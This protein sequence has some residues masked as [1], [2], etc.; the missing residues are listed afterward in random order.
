MAKYKPSNENQMVMLPISLQDQLVSG[1]L[2]HTISEL[3]DKHV[4]LS[5]FD[6]RYNNDLI[7]AAAIHPNVRAPVARSGTDVPGDATV[8]VHT[9]GC[10]H[11]VSDSEYMTGLLFEA[12]Y[13]ITD[14][15]AAADCY[16]VNS[17]TVKNP[18]EEHFVTLVRR[19]RAT[20][21][22]VIVAGCVPAG[23]PSGAEWRDVSVVSVRQIHRVT[24]V[25]SEALRGNTVRLFDTI[26]ANA[27]AGGNGAAR[28]A[29]P[30]RQASR[31]DGAAAASSSAIVDGDGAGVGSSAGADDENP[32]A[33]AG[34]S[35]REPPRSLPSL[36]LPKVRR[37]RFIEI[38][39]VNVGCLNSCTYCKTKHAR[40]DLQ[41]WPVAEILQRVR[42]C[43]AEGVTEI[44]LT[45][46]D[47]G[48]YGIDIGTDIVRLMREILAVLESTDVMVRLGMTN[49]PYLM[50]H[51]DAI[52]SLFL[53][54]NCFEFAHLP[55]QSGSDAI[56]DLM[57]RE[58]TV[59]D[60]RTC[61]AKLRAAA[62]GIS[63][64]TD[65]I[66]AFPFE[67]EAEWQQTMRLCNE[68]Q[69]PVLNI[70][71][72]YP[73][74][75]TP[76]AA[77][78]QIAS[79]VAKRRTQ[80]ISQMFNDRQSLPASLANTTWDMWLTDV[81]HDKHHLIGHTKQFVQVLVDPAEASLGDR[82]RVRIGGE[83]LRF[84]A[85]ATV[86]QV[87]RRANGI[88]PAAGRAAAACAAAAAGVVARGD[89]ASHQTASG[90]CD[91]C[92]SAM[93]SAV[94]DDDDD[95]RGNTTAAA[96]APAPAALTSTWWS[97]CQFTVAVAVVAAG[98][99]A[100]GG[101]LVWRHRAARR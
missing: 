100:V 12:G 9:F 72:Y 24:H 93:T 23:D 70:S 48:A 2:E 41:S 58:Y 29:K 37:N 78:Q 61:V 34:A 8:Y 92:G 85:K 90:Q 39:P 3:V 52:G 47:T 79:D 83:L 18:S 76:A 20:G 80:E 17:C 89:E 56:L 97:R 19:A 50:R 71:R 44:H 73:R 26:V 75:G 74:R 22:P 54:K 36:L 68:L 51:L 27:P 28:T 7:G 45:S 87:L 63:I 43:V 38:I 81:A 66:C 49:P 25:V 16:L 55:V 60:F 98:A 91:D 21:R 5:V 95:D 42:D 53:H 32:F 6:E 10:G 82:V 4:D 59:D 46:E 62:P 65:I 13:R 33:S 1:T 57:K 15:F 96:P 86:V 84:C 11:N 88:A 35:A 99:A 77:M 31:A 101:V 64:A 69:F 14:E 94:D 40:G 30:S 67:G